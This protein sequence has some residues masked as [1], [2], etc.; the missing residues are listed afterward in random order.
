MRRTL[1]ALLLAST[2][3]LTGACSEDTPGT[4]DSNPANQFTQ[5]PNPETTEPTE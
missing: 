4:G 3:L 5:A 1:A 2:A